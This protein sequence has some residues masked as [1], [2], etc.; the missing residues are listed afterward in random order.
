LLLAFV[1]PELALGGDDFRNPG[2]ENVI[3]KFPLTARGQLNR[4]SVEGNPR[5]AEVAADEYAIGD[6]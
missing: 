3:T 5:Q 6:F 2:S 4:S 1:L